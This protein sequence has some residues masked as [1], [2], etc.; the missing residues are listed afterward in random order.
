MV[1]SGLIFCLDARQKTLDAY[2]GLSN[3]SGTFPTCKMGTWALP[4]S[5]K[6][7][8]WVQIMTICMCDKVTVLIQGEEVAALKSITGWSATNQ[9]QPEALD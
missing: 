5:I 9:S 1:A 8:D 7:S 2:I 6:I 4:P 3:Y